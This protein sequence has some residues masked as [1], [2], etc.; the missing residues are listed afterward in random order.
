MDETM[1]G[2]VAKIA[3][4]GVAGAVILGAL[5]ANWML[6]K[7]FKEKEAN[8]TSAIDALAKAHKETADGTEQLGS[9]LSEEMVQIRLQLTDIHS[10]WKAIKDAGRNNS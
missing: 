9:K 1:I 3:N 7:H 6:L 4:A 2:I 5:A 10:Y 8:N